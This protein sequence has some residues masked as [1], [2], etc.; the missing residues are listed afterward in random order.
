MLSSHD[1]SNNSSNSS[2]HGQGSNSNADNNPAC[3]K[4]DIA[5]VGEGFQLL[6]SSTI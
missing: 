4:I 2:Y 3:N 6:S 1:I 5:V